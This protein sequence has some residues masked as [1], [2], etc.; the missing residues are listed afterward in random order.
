MPHFDRL[1]LTL[2]IGAPRRETLRAVGA[3][4]GTRFEH[5]PGIHAPPLPLLTFTEQTFAEVWAGENSTA[6]PMLP[7]REHL[8]APGVTDADQLHALRHG[9]PVHIV[10]LITRRQRPPTAHG[11]CFLSVENSTGLINVIVPAK[12]WA[13]LDHRTQYAGALL[14]YGTVEA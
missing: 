9:H 10:G 12:T 4:A 13:A 7:M 14:I 2:R 3:V 6:H 11:V 8:A 5:L 1:E